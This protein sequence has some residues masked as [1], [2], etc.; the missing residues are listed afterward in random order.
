MR[1]RK[2]GPEGKEENWTAKG[3]DKRTWVEG[4]IKSKRGCETEQSELGGDKEDG[5]WGG[6]V[7]PGTQSSGRGDV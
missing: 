5:G 3:D 1:K 2:N 4:V 6:C 7:R